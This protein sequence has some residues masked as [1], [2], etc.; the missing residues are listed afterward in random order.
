MLARGGSQGGIYGG[1]R[2]HMYTHQGLSSEASEIIDSTGLNTK[3]HN[4]EFSLS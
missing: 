2:G 1:G 4:S 3:S